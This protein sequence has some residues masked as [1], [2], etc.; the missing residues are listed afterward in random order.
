MNLQTAG[1]LL[2][3][4]RI[5]KE[6]SL[7]SISRQTKIKEKFLQALENSD[8]ASLPNFTIA[9]GFARSYA[10]A[11]DINPN[12]VAALLRRDFSAPETKKYQDEIHLRRQSFW[13]P[14]ATIFTVVIICVL[15]LGIYLGGQYLQFVAPPSV[16]INKVEKS[17]NSIVVIGTTTQSATVVVNGRPVLV[18]ND[19]S[20][21]IEIMYQDLIDSKV[22][23]EATSRSGKK[24]YISRTMN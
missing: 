23:V 24:S 18:E 3:D 12:T 16:T 1:L 19:G 21:K 22:V 10:Q 14:K 13:T 20:F 4:A 7:S 15:I 2:K 11:I 8:W 5:T 6:K 9:Q 17:Q